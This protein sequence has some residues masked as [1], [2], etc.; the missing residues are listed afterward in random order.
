[1]SFKCLIFSL[2]F[3]TLSRSSTQGLSAFTPSDS[4]FIESDSGNQL[5]FTYKVNKKQTLYG[6]S[7]YFNVGIDSLKVYNRE[8]E[9]NDLKENSLLRIPM[10]FSN[11]FI[12]D[13]RQSDAVGVFYKVKPGENL[14]HLSKRKFEISLHKLMQLNHLENAN[15][16]QSTVLLLGY[17]KL[18]SP[19]IIPEIP[20]SKTVLAPKPELSEENLKFTSQSRGVAV[21]EYDALGSGRLFALH[22]TAEMDSEIEIDNPIL[23]RKVY[24]KVI[25]RIPPIYEHDVQIVISGEAARMLGAVDKRFFVSIRYR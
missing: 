19:E 25:G 4:F 24:A 20:V 11:S 18:E 14:Y 23:N 13:S 10:D 6:I 2:L 9:K 15:I 22:N 8:L 7:K 5:Y 1:M 12:A 3:F 21:C 16:R 17:Y